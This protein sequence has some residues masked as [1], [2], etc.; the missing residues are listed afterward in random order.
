MIKSSKLSK[1]GKR[2]L[3]NLRSSDQLSASR[4]EDHMRIIVSEIITA[5]SN[6]KRG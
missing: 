5:L 3:I 6:S 2:F 1:V 4:K